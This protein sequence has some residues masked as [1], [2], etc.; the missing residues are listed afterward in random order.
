MDK[1]LYSRELCNYIIS[2]QQEDLLVIFDQFSDK[3]SDPEANTFFI[4]NEILDRMLDNLAKVKK[5]SIPLQALYKGITDFEKKIIS[6]LHI[7]EK[8]IHNGKHFVLLFLHL[9]N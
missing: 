4:Q 8:I 5:K 3:I 9:L 6:S 2:K 1:V 7:D